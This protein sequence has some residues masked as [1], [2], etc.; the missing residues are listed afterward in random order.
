MS[1]PDLLILGMAA[2]LAGLLLGSLLIRAL[3][4]RPISYIPSAYR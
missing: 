1:V 2:F 3:G 4:G